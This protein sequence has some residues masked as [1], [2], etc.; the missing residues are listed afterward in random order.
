MKDLDRDTL[1][2]L[3]FVK[4][5]NSNPVWTPDGSNIVFRSTDSAVPGLYWIRTDGSGEAQRLTDGD[6]SHAKLGK[7]ELFLGTPFAESSPM[8]S[9]DGRW[10]AYV[11]TQSETQE[12]YVRPFPGPGG[13]K[14]ISSGG[15]NYPVWS[16]NGCELLFQSLDQRV[17]AVS[18]TANGE[19]FIAGKPRV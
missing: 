3:S 15:G 13:R 9:P 10:L 8:F 5:T 6:V 2:R 7:P 1:S 17:M 11:S 12:I 16:K 18:F 14:Q 4:G 19:S